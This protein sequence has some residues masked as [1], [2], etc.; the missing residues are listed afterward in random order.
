MQFRTI[1]FAA[2]AAAAAALAAAPSHAQSAGNFAIGAQA[3]STGIGVN[4]QAALGSRLTL[5]GTADFISLSH[6]ATYSGVP[7]SGKFKGTTG[8][9]FLDVH[10][11]DN[12]FIVSA[13]AFGGR[14]KLEI[15]ATPQTPVNIGGFTFGAAET[16]ELKGDIRLSTLTPF[17]GAGFSNTFRTSGPLSFTAVAGVAFSKAPKVTLTSTGG[18]LSNDPT[19]QARLIQEEADIRRQVRNYRYYPAASIGVSYRF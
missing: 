12:P 14:R 7:Y 3:G 8:G 6:D 10:P 13:G 11:F 16:G 15:D 18:T 2:L 1:T 4:A 5:R 9:L 19:F 17:V